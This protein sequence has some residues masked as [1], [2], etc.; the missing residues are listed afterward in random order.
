[1]ISEGCYADHPRSDE[2]LPKP[3]RFGEFAAHANPGVETI[4]GPIEPTEA[5]R[6]LQ[7]WYG[8]KDIPA[9]LHHLREAS[10][11]GR[12]RWPSPATIR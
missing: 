2:L 9:T 11:A 12:T 8:Y 7:R 1:M 6:I 10:A 4:R 5:V 3:R